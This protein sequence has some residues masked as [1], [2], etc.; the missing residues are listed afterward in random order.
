MPKCANRIGGF[1]KSGDLIR[2]FGLRFCVV[3][4]ASPA[5]TRL[6]RPS[7]TIDPSSTLSSPPT[8][9]LSPLFFTFSFA[10]PYLFM[11]FYY[12]FSLSRSF[13]SYLSS[14][15]SLLFSFLGFFHSFAHLPPPPSRPQT[16]FLSFGHFPKRLGP[17]APAISSAAGTGM[18][19]ETLVGAITATTSVFGG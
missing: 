1:Q 11:S 8:F 13:P 17:S 19:L 7:V 3:L 15:R 6:A 9:P 12:P 18:R 16:Q 5:F 14:L 10:R 4:P 2:G